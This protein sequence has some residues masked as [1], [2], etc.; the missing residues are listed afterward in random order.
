MDELQT[1]VWWTEGS[2]RAA[3][4]SEMG[5]QTHALPH[6]PDIGYDAKGLTECVPKHTL[7]GTSSSGCWGLTSYNGGGLGADELTWKS[8]TLL[9]C[10]LLI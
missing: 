6:P 4:L 1:P 5:G 9:V 8:T 7:L 10:F 3:Q 2:R